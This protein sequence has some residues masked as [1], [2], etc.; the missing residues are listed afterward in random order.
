MDNIYID[1]WFLLTVSAAIAVY[2]VPVFRR[3]QLL[4]LC[5]VSLFVYTY[6]AS[7]QICFYC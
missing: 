6:V 4:V 5:G 1:A 3:V 2:Y 7:E